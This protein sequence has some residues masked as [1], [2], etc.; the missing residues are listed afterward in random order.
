[1]KTLQRIALCIVLLTM[2][3]TIWDC[4]DKVPATVKELVCEQEVEFV[5]P[6]DPEIKLETID[7]RATYGDPDAEL[8][9]VVPNES[10]TEITLCDP[11]IE[12]E[13][14]WG[15][16][17]TF[18]HSEPEPNEYAWFGTTKEGHNYIRVLFGLI[19]TWPDYIE[20]PKDLVIGHSEFTNPDG[21]IGIHNDIVIGKG[22]KIYFND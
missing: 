1:M 22:T 8:E 13:W 18:E 5:E 6:N 7:F 10:E 2:M 4:C 11:N 12:E 3:Y 15:V 19:P 16:E 17:G 9:I 20:L 21:S 14:I